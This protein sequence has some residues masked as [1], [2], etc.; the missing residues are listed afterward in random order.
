MAKLTCPY[1]NE[2]GLS[3]F[4]KSWLGPAFSVKCKKCGKKIGVPY[5]KALIACVP[6]FVAIIL[7]SILKFNLYFGL[8]IAFFISGIIYL[9]WVPIV[10]KGK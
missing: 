2:I 10:K 9:R 5:A 3:S 7:S 6:M 4:R 1:C 8:L